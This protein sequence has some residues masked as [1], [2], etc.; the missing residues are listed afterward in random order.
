M[1]HYTSEPFDFNEI[2]LTKPIALQGGSFF[3]KIQ[4]K[5]EPLY[6]Y[7]P[8]CHTS[9]IVASGSKQYAD[10]MFT[11]EDAFVQWTDAL[12]ERLQA[13]IFENRHTWFV[14]DSIELDDIQ[15]AFMPTLK[16]KQSQYTLRG[17]ILIRKH[18]WEESLQVFDERETPLPHTSV[19]DTKAVS[20]LDIHGLKFNDKSFQVVVYLRQMVVLTPS[21]FS[22]C[23][24]KIKEE[25]PIDISDSILSIKDVPNPE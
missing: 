8:K 15:H 20:I 24:I 1:I 3:S 9:G 5:T 2:T 6:I 14:T 17:N 13:L 19:K 21:L 4:K 25:F 10:L 16:F 23:K 7:S 12:E 11:K 18:P 22:E